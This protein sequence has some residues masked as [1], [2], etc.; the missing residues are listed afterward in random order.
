M[1]RSYDSNLFE[2]SKFSLDV[3]LATGYNEIHRTR[4]SEHNLFTGRLTLEDGTDGLSRNVCDKRL[5]P[6]NILEKQRQ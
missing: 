2:I 4:N 1:M 5:M 6:R 3:C